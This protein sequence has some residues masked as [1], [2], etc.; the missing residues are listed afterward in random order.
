MSNKTGLLTANSDKELA[1]NFQQYF[2]EKIQNVRDSF[3]P[4]DSDVPISTNIVKMV[5]FEPATEEE[6]QS[7]ISDYGISFSPEDPLHVNIVKEYK[8]ILLPF[9]LDL[10]NLSLTTGSMEC[11][12]S[13]IITPLLKDFDDLVDTETY[14]N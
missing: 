7:I 4:V 5:E 6:L 14:K 9:W 3:T 13:A 8:D 1:T 11:M 10:V 12:K 2:K